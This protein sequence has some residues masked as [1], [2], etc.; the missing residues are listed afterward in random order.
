MMYITTSVT[1][2]F[3][4]FLST[5]IK[6]FYVNTFHK[7]RFCKLLCQDIMNGKSAR[8]PVYDFKTNARV[9]GEFTMIYPSDV[10]VVEGILVFYFPGIRSEPKCRYC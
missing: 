7:T 3:I 9:P 8:I 10:V 2:I 1:V 5:I 6:Y 4:S